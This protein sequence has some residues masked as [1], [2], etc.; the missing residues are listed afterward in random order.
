MTR[1]FS[2]PLTHDLVDTLL[3]KFGG[4]VEK[5]H[6]ESV[7]EGVFK[8]RV[9]IRAQGELLTLDARP[10][11]CI[12]LALGNRAPIFVADAVLKE[13]AL[14]EEDLKKAVA[15]PTATVMEL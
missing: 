14:T 11:D 9:F 7:E 8:G 4:K 15:T 1:T 6:V 2:R 13:A 3:G 12:A 10:S 5:V